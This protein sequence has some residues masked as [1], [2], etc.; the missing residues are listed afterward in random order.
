M[1]HQIADLL[2]ATNATAAEMTHNLCLLGGGDMGSG[3]RN[4]W[5][6]GYGA[7]ALTVAVVIVGSCAL[8]W[9]TTRKRRIHKKVETVGTAF[10][11]GYEVGK[12]QERD[13]QEYIKERRTDLTDGE[14]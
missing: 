3:I 9:Y 5:I 7:G 8:S 12:R 10:N 6:D 4:L 11:A 13:Y 1:S 14:E 2:N